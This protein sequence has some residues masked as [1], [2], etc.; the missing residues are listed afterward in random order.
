MK[1]GFKTLTTLLSGIGIGY[2]PQKQAK[3]SR[4]STQIWSHSGLLLWQK[5]AG[6]KNTNLMCFRLSYQK[7]LSSGK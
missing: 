1:K 5:I 4:N 3:K 2:L 6:R 7:K